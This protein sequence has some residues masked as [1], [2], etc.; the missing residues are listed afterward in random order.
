MVS[1]PVGTVV[2]T[3]MIVVVKRLG[4]DVNQRG[5]P[6]GYRPRSPQYGSEPRG[7]GNAR[8]PNLAISVVHHLGVDIRRHVG[9]RI[10]RHHKDVL[11]HEEDNT[12]S[13]AVS[14]LMNDVVVHVIVMVIDHHIEVTLLEAPTFPREVDTKDPVPWGSKP[15]KWVICK[16]ANP[17]AMQDL[18]CAVAYK[19]ERNRASNSGADADNG[20]DGSSGILEITREEIFENINKNPKMA[21]TEKRLT[22]ASVMK[23]F[24]LEV[25]MEAKR[26]G[27][28][29]RSKAV[30]RAARAIR[31][32]DNPDNWRQVLGDVPLS[33]EDQYASEG[34]YSKEGL[35]FINMTLVQDEQQETLENLENQLREDMQ[36]R[37]E[38]TAV[39][40]SDLTAMQGEAVAGPEHKD[41]QASTAV[42]VGASA[43]KPAMSLVSA[44]S[45]L[46][47]NE[48][49][50]RLE[51]SKETAANPLRI[52]R[53][54]TVRFPVKDA[55]NAVRLVEPK[56]VNY[57]PRVAHDL[58]SMIKALVNNGFKININKRECTLRHDDDGYVLSA[59]GG[60]GGGVDI[61]LLRG[62][63]K[64][65]CALLAKGNA[66]TKEALRRHRRAGHPGTE[67][68]LH[69]RQRLYGCHHYDDHLAKATVSVEAILRDEDAVT[70]AHLR[71]RQRR[72]VEVTYSTYSGTEQKRELPASE[73]IDNHAPPRT[74]EV[75]GASEASATFG[76]Q[77]TSA[78]QL[79]QPIQ[80]GSAQVGETLLPAIIESGDDR[81]V[82]PQRAVIPRSGEIASTRADHP[83]TWSVEAQTHGTTIGNRSEIQSHNEGHPTSVDASRS[84]ADVHRR[85]DVA[86]MVARAAESGGH[87]RA[88]PGWQ[89]NVLKQVSL[90]VATTDKASGRQPRKRKREERLLNERAKVDAHRNSLQKDL[91]GR[92]CPCCYED[93]GAVALLARAGVSAL[94][95]RSTCSLPSQEDTVLDYLRTS[96][97]KS[98]QDH[99]NCDRDLL[100]YELFVY[101]LLAIKYVTEPQSYKQAIASGEAAQWGKAMDSEIQSHEDNETWILV[102]R[103]KGRNILQ[104]RWV[105][106]IKSW[107]QAEGG[108]ELEGVVVSH[109]KLDP[110]GVLLLVSGVGGGVV[111]LVS[112]V[113]GGVALLVECTAG[114]PLHQRL[115]AAM[116]WDVEQVDVK[117][118]F[119]NGYLDE[120][121]YMEQPV[122]YVQRGK[123]DHVC[124][125]RESLYGLKQ[126]PRVWYYTFYE[127]MI[128]ERF[129][130]LVKDHC[131]FIKTRGR[132]ICIISVC[133]DDLL[134]IDT[135]SF[136]AE[137]KEILKRRFQMT[138]LGG[139]SYLLGWHIARRRSECI[140]FVHQEKYATKVLDRFGLA[141]CR[142]VRSPEETSQKLSESDCPTT[143]AEKQEMDMLTYREAVGSFMYLMMGT[144]PD[145][146]NFV[147][148][149][150]RYLHNPG[151]HHWNYVVRG[152]K[153][154]NGTRDYDIALGAR[155][156]ANATLAHALSVYSDADYAN[157]MD[158]RRS[159]V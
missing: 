74:G 119:L 120:E 22:R 147:H 18:G 111:L 154:M 108:D 2:L 156:L 159:V 41:V 134:V 97:I 149:V 47:T 73:A 152:L 132:E 25:C 63:G 64:R 40:T 10:A 138:D 140:I 131:V 129:I 56:D 91:R 26:R 100:S 124:A 28:T 81:T 127:V 39:A 48:L 133:V 69:E 114:V 80:A 105:Y 122:A 34:V 37:E 112:G 104:N 95:V 45:S 12:I 68:W 31:C 67:C 115:A 141:Q 8:L 87:T 77:R 89:G 27:Y 35:K 20:E 57:V 137:I 145:L 151:P 106:V 7:Y 52:L 43:E 65:D 51:S 139:V 88:Y 36:K 75:I 142:P 61:Y 143:D 58:F 55:T 38:E 116:D 117:T 121:I 126:A 4:G 153:Y 78:S 42:A 158:T 113:G 86:S 70:K 107:R 125:L 110:G 157:N 96:G 32:G 60:G 30:R 44:T 128:A 14:I 24:D 19:F 150:S 92:K 66:N 49:T 5:L 59:P 146:A 93:E 118:V 123:E 79:G 98:G 90:A 76:E 11:I 62:I 46:N 13:M 53:K 136:V 71:R 33:P 82:V 155:Y 29:D 50:W 21:H 16:C 83:S 54:G 72:T 144:R 130:R 15:R 148:Q 1:G 84:Q 109:Y 3:K 103:P 99:V 23:C 101:A 135:K 9:G 102:P 17:I 85:N 6:A 94:K